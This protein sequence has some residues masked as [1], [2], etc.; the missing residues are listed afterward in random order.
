MGYDSHTDDQVKTRWLGAQLITDALF[1]SLRQ[2]ESIATSAPHGMHLYDPHSPLPVDEMT[3]SEQ[4]AFALL[5]RVKTCHAILLGNGPSAKDSL[6]VAVDDVARCLE[7]CLRKF[8]ERRDVANATFAGGTH[9]ALAVPHGEYL[10]NAFAF[11]EACKGVSLFLDVVEGKKA[12]N[13][14]PKERILGLREVLDKAHA[15]IR[16]DAVKVKG[17]LG[18]AASSRGVFRI[19]PG[20][21]PEKEESLEREMGHLIDESWTEK[22]RVELV[23]SWRDAIDG[24]LESI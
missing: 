3:P 17:R 24:L 10:H 16:D 8:S 4:A 5:S 21:E 6:K 12:R 18:D 14:V 19:S 1:A 9:D 11:L 22:F 15:S 7:A 23:A 13:A 20:R 2:Q